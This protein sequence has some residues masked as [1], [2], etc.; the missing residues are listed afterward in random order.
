MRPYPH[1]GMDGPVSGRSNYTM[2][3]SGHIF[4]PRIHS[5]APGTDIPMNEKRQLIRQMLEMQKTFME[6]EKTQGIDFE[7]YYAAEGGDELAKYQEQYT[8]LANRLVELAHQE[9]G[10]SR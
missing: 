4:G 3:A 2:C 5:T 1:R 7:N 10:S 6:I 9:K 8:E